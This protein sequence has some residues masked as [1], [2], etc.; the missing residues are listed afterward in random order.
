MSKYYKKL[1]EEVVLMYLGNI[2][3]PGYYIHL[4][5]MHFYSLFVSGK[6]SAILTP[7]KFPI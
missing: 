4:S 3:N 2:H 1:F 5:L 7:T 6:W